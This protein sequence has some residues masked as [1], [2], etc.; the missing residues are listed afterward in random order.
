MKPKLLLSGSQGS[1]QNRKL[2]GLKYSLFQVKPIVFVSSKFSSFKYY[3]PFRCG[4]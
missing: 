2:I 4:F 3:K 1:S